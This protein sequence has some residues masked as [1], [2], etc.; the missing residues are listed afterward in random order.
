[1][2]KVEAALLEG[3]LARAMGGDPGPLAVFLK[4]HSNLPGP[5]GNLELAWQFADAVAGL[6][7]GEAADAAWRTVGVLAGVGPE[8][9][10]TGDP[11]EFLAFCGTLGAAG[12][13]ADP[14]RRPAVW[15]AVRR[16][17]EDERWRLRE[18]AAQAIQR[19]LPADPPGALAVLGEWAAGGPWLLCRAVAAGLADPPL[20]RDEGLAAAAL[21]LHEV[22]LARFL[23]A[24]DRRDEDF[25]VLRQGLGYTLSVV[26]AA[27]PEPGFALLRRLAAVPDRDLAW[28]LRSNLGKGRLA[29]AYPRE[30][31]AVLAL[32]A[33]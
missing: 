31:E 15:E 29:R 3:V 33:G 2:P 25:K 14:A 26:V 9:A 21:R 11:G 16:A 4:A 22:I 24:G 19:V 20:L 18:G 12:F 17:A 27:A 32:L 28:V 30:V 23:A 5:R 1:L 8:E 10:P 6:A 13:A 7:R